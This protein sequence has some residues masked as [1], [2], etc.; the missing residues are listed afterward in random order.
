ME[1][2]EAMMNE[3]QAEAVRQ[4]EGPLLVLAGAGSGKTRVLTHRVA[5]LIENRGV[6]PWHILAITFTNK[7]AQEMRERVNRLIGA[8]ASEIWVSTFHSMC[9]RILRRNIEALGYTRDFSIYDTEDQ[10]T[11]MKQIFKDLN[12]DSKLLRER[13]VLSV[14]STAKNS[15]T[16]AASFQ[17][18]AGG[19]LQERRI[20]DCY[21]E[22]EKRLRQNNALDFDDLLLRTLELLRKQEEVRAYYQERFRYILVDEYQDTNDVQFE[23]VHILA[24]RYRNICVVGD[25]DQ[26]I[27][28]FRGAN[29]ENILSFEK[30]YPGA[31]VV[32][33]E[34]NY[35]STEKILDTANA[36]ISHNSGRKDKRMW[37]DR[38][39]GAAVLFQEYETA[40]EE[41]AAVVR[42]VRDCG[43]AYSEQAVL[44]R[45][46]AQSRLL[47]EQCVKWNVPYRIIGG[48]NFYQRREIKD[49]LAY[50]KLVSNDADDV[51]FE[52]IINVP[53]RS[54]G[55]SSLAK[56]RSHAAQRQSMSQPFSLFS[57][58]ET[59][60]QSGLSGRALK[61]VQHFTAQIHEWREKLR[62]AGYLQEDAAPGMEESF[63]IRELIESIRDDTGYGM[64]LRAEGVVEAETR[65]MNIEEVISKAADYQSSAEQPKLSEFL[66]EVSLVSDLDRAEEG[67][68]CLTLMTLH[69]AKGL[70]F[71]KVY[72]VGLSDGLF[73]GFSSIN[74]PEELEEERRLCYV[75]IT[76]AEEELVMSSARS[77][78]MNG[79]YQRLLPSRFVEEMP[80]S[81]V[82]KKLLY[83]PK[84]RDDYDGFSAYSGTPFE[85]ENDSRTNSYGFSGMGSLGYRDSGR[86]GGPHNVQSRAGG[87]KRSGPG[88]PSLMQKGMDRP[89]LEH[90]DYGVGDRVS[91]V[92]FGTGTVTE[93][94]QD[95]RDF[96][97]TVDFDGAGR[98]KMF[99]SFARLMKL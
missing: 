38:K 47:E 20:A 12:I 43:R 68:D 44:Y 87:R 94:T 17:R 76:R 16:D 22:Y 61:S 73:P 28:S 64:E 78:M 95:K 81:V 6:A 37:T 57:A 26:S 75:G 60:E 79:E 69:G 72:L 54:V 7:A 88:I 48:V 58:A 71:P 27:Y 50:M 11:V 52:R 53:K 99:A 63:S 21:L 29:L 66:E 39:G 3:R 23:L 45:T 80:D 35:R 46:N 2:L 90:L 55:A 13:A 25:D 97:V 56:L 91:H 33:L 4:T 77:R 14:I 98:K 36:V 74:E 31:K 84:P 86:Q 5:Y 82:R 1:N 9:V 32:K 62:A 42:E 83:V 41:A 15:G 30:S 59:A 34:Q 24:E 19:S 70:E 96:M 49:V 93:I 67:T 89:K 8:R 51:A 40:N 85:E 18:E 10:K 92:K 65:L